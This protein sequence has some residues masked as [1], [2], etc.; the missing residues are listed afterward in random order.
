MA[1]YLSAEECPQGSPEWH[2]RR[3]GL[4]TASEITKILTASKL[5]KS[6]SFADYAIACA[7]EAEGFASKPEPPNFAMR[8]GIE[9]EAEAAYAFAQMHGEIYQNVS[10]VGF[11]LPADKFAVNSE[12][13]WGCSPDRLLDDVGLLEIKCPM[14]AETVVAYADAGVVPLKYK[15][16]CQ[17]QL[18]VCERSVLEF[19]AYHRE[20]CFRCR[21]IP[22]EATFAAF[23]ELLPEFFEAVRMHREQLRQ[24]AA[25]FAAA[26]ADAIRTAAAG[27]AFA[28]RL[29]HNFYFEF[30]DERG[31]DAE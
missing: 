27:Q 21:V 4:A 11:V 19:F 18:W 10:E 2:A 16:Q 6:T 20:F 13:G 17:F 24:W 5:K 30:L 14:K 28:G 3:Q 23:G 25:P 29:Y 15:L 31:L 8:H 9:T 22:D 1:K 26:D 7:I 12:Y